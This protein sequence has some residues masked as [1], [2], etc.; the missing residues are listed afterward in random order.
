VRDQL[1][2]RLLE[3]PPAFKRVPA[4]D[5]VRLRDVMMAAV[6]GARRFG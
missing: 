3:P 2:D 5:P 6:I 4:K 1:M